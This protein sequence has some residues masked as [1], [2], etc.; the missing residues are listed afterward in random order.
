MGRRELRYA[1][2]TYMNLKGIPEQPESEMERSRWMASTSLHSLPSEL[3]V[4]VASNLDISSYLA[5]ASSST[6]I[7]DVLLSETQWKS[8]LQ[9]TRMNSNRLSKFEFYRVS[10]EVFVSPELEYEARE[11]FWENEEKDMIE[12]AEELA[13]FLKL[14]RNS[15][16]DGDGLL[17][18][19]LHTICKRFPA[20]FEET[21]GNQL[22]VSLSCVC[23]TMHEVTSFGFA[24]I[25]LVEV[26]VRG[27]AAPPLLE[28]VAFKDQRGK[29]LKEVASRVS[30]QKEQVAEVC[31]DFLKSEK[32][33]DSTEAWLTLLNHCKFWTIGFVE[34][35]SDVNLLQGLAEMADKGKIGFLSISANMVSQWHLKQKM[36][37]LQKVWD[38][39]KEGW[40]IMCSECGQYLLFPSKTKGTESMILPI[41]DQIQETAAEHD[42]DCGNVV[43]K[44]ARR[45]RRCAR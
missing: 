31:V 33:V 40:T 22:M 11:V 37:G 7:L 39:S 41:F 34:Q 8:I 32:D 2:A 18:S 15:R 43:R 10:N 29:H 16:D 28:L 36:D 44:K 6:I 42:Q 24:L 27:A 23:H 13:L 9:K 5:M 19:F 20:R 35:V 14:V 17:L 4:M 45:P 25:E 21:F 1:Y 26:I 38:I 30:R 12:E 3:M